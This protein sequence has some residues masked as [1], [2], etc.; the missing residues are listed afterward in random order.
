[1]QREKI[2][3]FDV[4]ITR[5]KWRKVIMKPQISDYT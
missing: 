4:N 5:Q 2:R 1:M 3:Q